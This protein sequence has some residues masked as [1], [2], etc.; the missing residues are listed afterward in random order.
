MA[1]FY[2]DV[3]GPKMALD[4]DGTQWFK[5]TSAGVGTPLTSTEI[6]QVND[7]TDGGVD[8][9]SGGWIA[10]VFPEKRDLAGVGSFTNRSA[11]LTGILVVETS[12]NTT[13]GSDGTWAT[14]V[15]YTNTETMAS[16]AAP[17]GRS[18]IRSVT[19]GGV[20][21]VRLK[22]TGGNAFGA[23]TFHVYGSTTAGQTVDRL[24][25]WH[26]T[27]D[28]EVGGAYLDWGDVKRNTTETRTFRVKNLSATQ[29][30]NSPRVAMEALTDASPS[31]V[32]QHAISADGSTWLSQITMANLAPGAI[33]P[34]LSVR[35]TT[36]LTAQ[37][38]IWSMRLFAEATTW[39]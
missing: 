31:V 25:F 19:T 7:W 13:N 24:A 27:L 18:G 17:P 38:S 3:P 16:P 29:T 33:S 4:K 20:R 10:A 12:T 35:R 39:S 30:A 2:P 34:V 9:G 15:T 21:G 8:P 22:M 6:T 26:P 1:G 37:P 11:Q 28:Q 23:A 14:Q 36:P 5:Y 32:G